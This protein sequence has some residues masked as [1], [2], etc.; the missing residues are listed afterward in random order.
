VRKACGQCSA[1]A[2]LLLLWLNTAAQSIAP[3]PAFR[4]PAERRIEAARQAIASKPDHVAYTELAMALARRARETA[5]SAYYNQAEEALRL[6]LQFAPQNFEAQKARVWVLLGKHDFVQARMAAE[7]LNRSMP[8]DVQVYGLLADANAELG[9]YEAAENAVQWMLDL[10]PGN[11]PALTRAAYLRELFGDVEGAL[12]LMGS[13]FN[14]IP[15]TE[16]E[17]R[18]WILTHA[19]S[20]YLGIGKLDPANAALEQA[21]ALFPDYHYALGQLAKLRLAQGKLEEA[22][23]LFERRY[24]TAPHAENLFAL[25]VALDR[26]GRRD[27]ARNAFAEFERK[28]RAEMG[29][30]DNSNRELIFYYSD[31]ASRPDEALRIAEVEVARRRDV[32]TREAYAWALAANRR[33]QEARAQ[34]EQ[35]L[36]VGVKDA[37]M[38]YR[39][40]MIAAR[41]GDHAAA[42]TFLRQS[43]E[44]NA[45]AA[46][47]AEARD[48]L[49]RLQSV[50][51]IRQ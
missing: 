24:R 6:S 28:S 23:S 12:E 45:S 39:A 34:I 47:A 43:L 25:A 8:D 38:Y 44:I 42:R 2:L 21:L 37:D 26:S 40:G 3:E 10:R 27:D 11:V 20:L 4:S 29:L 48:E 15:E 17:E 22:V 33:E 32:H 51:V 46:H 49:Q 50:D 16:T 35:A 14:R 18:A 1:G 13:A 19:G 30:T 41:Q 9:E 36:A 31:Y 5:D 7:A